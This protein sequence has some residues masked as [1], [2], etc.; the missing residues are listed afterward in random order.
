MCSVES[1]GKKVGAEPG[2][3]TSTTTMAMADMANVPPMNN[4]MR[5]LSED[6]LPLDAESDCCDEL[7]GQSASSRT[8]ARPP[9]HV[10]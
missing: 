9:S 5:L 10:M 3:R 8:I 4:I 1:S 2:L 6:E 7:L